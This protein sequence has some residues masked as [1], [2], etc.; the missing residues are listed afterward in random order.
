MKKLLKRLA[1]PTAMI[2]LAIG[3]NACATVGSGP[4]N[5]FTYDPPV[6]QPKNPKNVQMK[7]STGASRLYI[8][9]GNDVLLA[10][11]VSVGTSNTPTPAGTFKIYSKQRH[12]RR[13][14]EPGAGYPMT[15]WMEFKP[16]Y[17]LHWGFIKPYPS[18]MGCVRMPLKAAK[19]VF[20]L[21]PTGSTI[22][23]ASSQP[24]DATIGK[25]LPT[26][27]DGPL[28]NPPMSYLMSPQV[29]ADSEKGKMWNF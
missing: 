2:A 1:A 3:L 16:A 28:P 6:T 24:W 14:S 26:L 10:T 4:Q 21:V 22:N 27:D 7:L 17:G 12:R 29:F 15:Y 5:S 25:S 18:T 20:D 13:F 23:I 8:V 9:E 11:P 19:K